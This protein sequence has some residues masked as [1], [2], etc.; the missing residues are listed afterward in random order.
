MPV[1]VRRDSEV[2]FSIVPAKVVNAF[3][4]CMDTHCINRTSNLNSTYSMTVPLLNAKLPVY[5][6]ACK[7]ASNRTR[8][9]NT[10]FTNPSTV[11]LS[12]PT[13]SIMPTF[14]VQLFPEIWSCPFLYFPTGKQNTTSWPHHIGKTLPTEKRVLPQLRSA[15]GGAA[16]M[17]MMKLGGPEK[18]GEYPGPGARLHMLF[19]RVN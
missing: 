11:S 9:R 4:N 14:C 7:S 13:R 1:L 2:T 15:S 12:I 5:V 3:S 10:L 17:L 19:H 6:C 8:P 16:K 18:L